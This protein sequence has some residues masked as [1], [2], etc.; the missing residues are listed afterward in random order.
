MSTKSEE[1]CMFLLPTQHLTAIQFGNH[2]Y[3]HT[4]TS[5]RRNRHCSPLLRLAA[6]IRNAIYVLVLGNRT[7]HFHDAISRPYAKL[8]TNG[9]RHILSLLLV[10]HQI[11]S[12]ASLFPYSLNTFSFRETEIS[13]T[14]FLLHRRLAHFR[15]I[16]SIELMTSQC[17]RMW[18]APENESMSTVLK[19]TRILERLPNLRYIRVLVDVNSGL[20]SDVST[21]GL[22]SIAAVCDNQKKLEQKIM[23]RRED[24]VVTFSW[25]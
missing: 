14:P 1:R 21:R 19:D 8:K 13:L 20:Y 4:R 7:Y 2:T 25:I 10:C 6:E 23:R 12:E 9:E 24:V 16:K 22:Y 11:Y 15:A 5:T 18:A 3:T 17:A